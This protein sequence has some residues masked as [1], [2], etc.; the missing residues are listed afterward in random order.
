VTS[1]NT[2]LIISKKIIDQPP[3]E[4]HLSRKHNLS[5]DDVH[6]LAAIQVA[7]NG[8]IYVDINT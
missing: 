6:F 5:M 1:I 7:I 3:L 4:I 8:H 2:Q